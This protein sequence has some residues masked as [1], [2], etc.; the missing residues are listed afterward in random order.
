[1]TKALIVVA[2]NFQDEEFVY[3]FYKLK[4]FADV[5]V[6]SSDGKDRFG[7]YGVPARVTHKFSEI[8]VDELD[9]L[10]IPGGFEC[11][12]RLR[13]DQDCLNIVRKCVEKN[14]LVAAI[15]HGPW[16]LISAGVT[17]GIPMTGYLAIH[18]D[19]ANSGAELDS[20]NELVV[21][22]NFISAQHYRN[23]PEF[24]LAVQKKLIKN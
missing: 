16:V 24:M 8:N 19:L 18:T 6:A 7:K 10:L 21:S 5:Y 15:C 22:E 13:I 17:K 2:Q 12:D 20:K 14:I 1:M 23:N 11:P 9:V 3:P 4:E